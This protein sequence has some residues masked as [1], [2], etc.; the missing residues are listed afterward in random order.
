[1]DH[2]WS[3]DG[4]LMAWQHLKNM[5]QLLSRMQNLFGIVEFSGELTRANDDLSGCEDAVCKV[6]DCSIECAR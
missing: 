4:G 1:M 5:P 2:A 6:C 3:H